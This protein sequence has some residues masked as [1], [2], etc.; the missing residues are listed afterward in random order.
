MNVLN[1]KDNS[2]GY[3]AYKSI[4]MQKL[5]PRANELK[6]SLTVEEFFRYYLNRNKNLTKENILK[7]SLYKLIYYYLIE[8]KRLLGVDLFVIIN[9]SCSS[10]HL[11]CFNK[12]YPYHEYDLNFIIWKYQFV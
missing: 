1:G 8:S 12:I 11:R 10:N 2:D 5:H 9:L 4:V 7:I 3:V 6:M